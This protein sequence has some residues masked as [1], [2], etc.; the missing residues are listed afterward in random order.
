MTDDKP[1]VA[2]K[3]KNKPLMIQGEVGW[4]TDAIAGGMLTRNGS[5]ASTQNSQRFLDD[6]VCSSNMAKLPYIYFGARA[7][8]RPQ[9][10]CTEGYDEQWK[11]EKYKGSEGGFSLRQPQADSH[12][13]LGLAQLQ[14][15]LPQ[16]RP[17][18]P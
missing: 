14:G 7:S 13:I 16:A 11:L 15:P 4:P 12:S 1:S 2:R 17:E 5:A 8:R 18:D 10:T 6:W 9:L 3:A